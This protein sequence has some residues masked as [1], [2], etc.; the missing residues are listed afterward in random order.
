MKLL[1]KT[2]MTQ[3]FKVTEKELI[4]LIDV[5][6]SMSAMCL[7]E[8]EET[9][10]ALKAVKKILARKGLQKQKDMYTVPTIKINDEGEFI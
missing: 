2:H 3:Y 8:D 1:K 7:E 5:V 6:D 9:P 10:K 4:V